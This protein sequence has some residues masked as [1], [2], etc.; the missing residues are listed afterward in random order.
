[1]RLQG[2]YCGKGGG[3]EDKRGNVNQIPINWESSWVDRHASM[4]S[5]LQ[6][7]ELSL[8][9]SHTFFCG[10]DETEDAC[11]E[12][13]NQV[14]PCSPER[15]HDRTSNY[16][17]CKKGLITELRLSLSNNRNR[18]SHCHKDCPDKSNPILSWFPYDHHDSQYLS[19][20][21]YDSY[22]GVAP[23]HCRGKFWR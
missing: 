15:L 13:L 6:M 3:S 23:I 22:I 18:N 5:G 16:I 19:F 1:M 2:K 20:P 11:W 9:S 14:V 4:E 17:L 8:E 21:I 7:S 12:L 10:W